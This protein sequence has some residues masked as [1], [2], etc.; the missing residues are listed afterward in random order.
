[1][2]PKFNYD[3]VVRVRSNAPPELRPG[4][5]AWV[6]GVFDPRPEGSYF[7]KFPAGVVYS[8]E[9]EDGVSIEIHENDLELKS[10]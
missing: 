1:M 8:V 7:E 4:E 9:F 10:V 6:V 5:I 2:Q 3:D